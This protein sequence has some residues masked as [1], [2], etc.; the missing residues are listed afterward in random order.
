M[1]NF[2]KFLLPVFLFAAILFTNG[3]QKESIAE[4]QENKTALI[5]ATLSDAQLEAVQAKLAAIPAPDPNLVSSRTPVTYSQL[6]PGPPT[7]GTATEYSV[8]SPQNWDYYSFEGLA[9]QEV[10]IS[11]FR[12]EC[13]NELAMSLFFGTTNNTNGVSFNSG[14]PNMTFLAFQDDDVPSCGCAMDPLLSGFILPNSGTYTLA[15]FNFGSCGN[16][17]LDYG[18]SISGITSCDAD[19]DGCA[20]NVDPHPNSNASAMVM[21]DGCN[22]GVPNLFVNSCSN[23]LDMIGD[24]AA[25]TNNHGQFVSCVTQKANKWKKDGL[26]TGA[27]KGAIVSC[28]AQSNLP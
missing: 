10:T 9:G 3:C 2:Q 12:I 5:Q 18:V 6:C 7:Y 26:I 1:K 21:I 11:A 25:G 23:I 19:G 14:G 28:A 24:C 15:V 17:M 16:P 13:D 4:L 8:N 22:S 20:D 27:Q